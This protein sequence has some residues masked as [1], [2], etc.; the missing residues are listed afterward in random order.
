MQWG[1]ETQPLVEGPQ[2]WL[3]SGGRRGKEELGWTESTRFG[4]CTTPPPH[5]W[6]PIW[7]FPFQNSSSLT[8]RL[9]YPGE[10]SDLS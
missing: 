3:S 2:A 4:T 1:P 9:Y 7:L 8:G 5:H 10:A 6:N